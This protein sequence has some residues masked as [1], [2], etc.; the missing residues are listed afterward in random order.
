MAYIPGTTCN[1]YKDVTIYFTETTPAPDNGYVVRWKPVS[2]SIYTYVTPNVT[3]SPCVLYNIPLCEAINVCISAKCSDQVASTETCF[4]VSMSRP[5][6]Y[7][8]TPC[9]FVT[10]NNLT[11]SDVY[12]PQG[13]IQLATGVQLV[14]SSG[15]AVSGIIYVSDANGVV[16]NVGTSG[17]VGTPT[18]DSC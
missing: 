1:D 12:F 6:E 5:I 14:N 7:Y 17:I 11:P 3:S 8:Y 13:V 16:Y 9:A 4:I 18:G 15:N 10:D 2:G